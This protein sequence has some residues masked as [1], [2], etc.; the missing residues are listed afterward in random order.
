M[1]TVGGP[2]PNTQKKNWKMIVNPDVDG[3]KPQ[4]IENTP[5]NAKKEQLIENQKNT[6]YQN[7]V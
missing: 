6:K 3:L 5:K 7:T 1:A 4:I 2:L